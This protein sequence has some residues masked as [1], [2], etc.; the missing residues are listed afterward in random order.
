LIGACTTSLIKVIGTKWKKGKQLSHILIAEFY[1]RKNQ[2]ETFIVF[3]SHIIIQFIARTAS[4][5]RELR[6]TTRDFP[7][8]QVF[9]DGAAVVNR[10]KSK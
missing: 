2:S 4:L 8:G 3:G 5:Y 9:F 1:D 10:H 6:I 7:Y